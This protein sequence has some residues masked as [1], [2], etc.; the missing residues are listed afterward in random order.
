MPRFIDVYLDDDVPGYPCVS[1]PRFNNSIIMADSAS[2]KVNI[3]WENALYKFTLPQAI[4]EHDIVESI[5]DHWLVMHGTAYTFPFRDPTD[6][7]SVG[8]DSP[9]VEPDISELDQQIGIGDGVTTEFQLVK[10]YIKGLSSYTR[11][12][13]HP[14]LS[15]VSISDNSVL[16]DP[17]NYSVSRSTGI[18]T[19][20]AAPTALHV[21]R[22]G[23][24]FDI[25]VRFES[26]DSFESMV[27]NFLVSG[28]SDLVLLE[29]RSCD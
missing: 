2:E 3:R 7:A 17:S 20:D 18:V 16:V 24:F 5:R 21:I 8:L 12:I 19:F 4:R 10:K 11:T 26:N 25:E 22:A 29:V 1:I 6:F 27:A 9:N 15:S 28:F 23:Y 13:Y 14:V